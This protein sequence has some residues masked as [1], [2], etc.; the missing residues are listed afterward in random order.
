[1]GWWRGAK[2]YPLPVA[3]LAV[4]LWLLFALLFVLMW[5]V[6]LVGWLLNPI[7]EWFRESRFWKWLRSIEIPDPIELYKWDATE[8]YDLMVRIRK[9]RRVVLVLLGLEYTGAIVL[10]TSAGI[11]GLIGTGTWLQPLILSSLI[12]VVA[13]GLPSMFVSS[14][15][16][17]LVACWTA[18]KFTLCPVCAYIR[19]HSE[20]GRCPDCGLMAPP[21]APGEMPPVWNTWS[22]L[23]SPRSAGLPIALIGTVPYVCAILGGWVG[24]GA[25]WQ[26]VLVLVLTAS[27]VGLV[28]CALW[29]VRDK[30]RF[31]RHVERMWKLTADD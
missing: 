5:P 13:L 30:S 17:R 18:F 6:R 10:G 28:C 16:E 9:V 29:R 19:D 31:A 27:L 21:L 3:I 24:L 8:A 2:T 26:G 12:I 20:S 25:R 7:V 11:G 14:Y 23:M 1:M 4:P 15:Y 22:G